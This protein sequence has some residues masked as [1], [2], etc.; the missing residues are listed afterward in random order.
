M[1]TLGS[2]TRRAGAV[3]L[4]ASP[5]GLGCGGMGAMGQAGTHAAGAADK[6]ALASALDAPLAV[7]G[8]VRPALRV[9]LPGSAA[10]SLRLLSAR[11]EILEVKDGLLAGR[12]PG[13]SAVLVAMDGDV[14]LDFVHIWV[15]ATD[16]VAVHGLDGAGGDLGPLTEPLELVVGEGT[17][18]VPHPYAGSERLIGVA[19]STWVVDPPI[20]IV[21]REG[22]PNRVRLVARAPG[23]AEVRVT[24]LGATHKLALQVVP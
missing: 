6:G 8:E 18:L 19:T 17:R 12:S 14:V 1:S 15:K 3:A 7:G 2:A 4:L 11:P 24:M 13:M 22:L 5:L 9:E 23:K 21:L 16:R 10:P 20:A